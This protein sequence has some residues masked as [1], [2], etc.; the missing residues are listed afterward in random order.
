MNKKISLKYNIERIEIPEWAKT[1]I[2]NAD[3]TVSYSEEKLNQI[4]ALFYKVLGISDNSRKKYALRFHVRFRQP[5]TDY[6][7]EFAD[8]IINDRVRF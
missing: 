5:E 4:Y 2:I 1:V 6:Y 7:V 8:M 3:T